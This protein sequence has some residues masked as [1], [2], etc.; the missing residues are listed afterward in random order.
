MKQNYIELNNGVM[1][2]QVGYGTF[3]VNDYEETVKA[4][5]TAIE[6]GY[7]H[8]DTAMIYKNEEAVGEAIRNSG[9][10][11]K[12]LFVTSKVWNSD[13]GYEQTLAAFDATLQRLGLDYLDLYL[14]H[15]PKEMNVET[16]KA[17]ESLY[18]QGK[19]RAIGVSNFKP[20]HLQAI[21]DEG[22]IVPVVNQVELH[23]QF[24]QDELQAMCQKHN[25]YLEAWGPIMQGQVDKLNVLEPIATK[26]NKSVVQVALHWSIQKG[27][28]ILPKSVTPSRM[29]ENLELFDFELTDED[30]NFIKQ[31]D[32][33]TRIGPDPDE[34]T[35]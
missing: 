5:K 16:W 8:I 24:P 9:V 30:M 34:I 12:E 35:F 27:N 25:I 14:I 6:L 31:L 19:I 7:R 18:K 15:W 13:H 28:I 4:V 20:H 11:R 1:I 21:L 26:Y 22:E 17:M 33:G 23:P 2:P 29:Q 3:K 10:D 32:T